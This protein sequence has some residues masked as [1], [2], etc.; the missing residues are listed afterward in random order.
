M[1]RRDEDLDS[2]VE[3]LLQKY[4]KEEAV[5]LRAELVEFLKSRECRAQLE[6]T[7]RK[8][9]ETVI[10]EALSDP[11]FQAQVRD[12]VIASLKPE[13]AKAVQAALK[14]VT[15]TI[16]PETQAQ[17]RRD[18]EEMVRHAQ[19]SAQRDA[20]A[21]THRR[22]G[23]GMATNDK[24]MLGALVVILIVLGVGAYFFWGRGP[25]VES[26]DVVDL[27][28]AET[29]SLPAETTT[30]APPSVPLLFDRYRT[31]LTQA[32][33]P[34]LPAPSPA[35]LTCV[36]NA[37]RQQSGRTPLDVAALRASLNS[38]AATK[39]RPAAP[40]RIIAGVQAQLTEEARGGS[41]RALSPVTIDGRHGNETSAAL[42]TYVGCT[43]PVGVPRTLQTLGDYAAVG[44]YFIDKR[45][46]DAG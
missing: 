14:D 3:G 20:L 27:P 41:C 36:D 40:S 19:A 26:P 5:V 37:I 2:A 22:L 45:M 11:K 15:V 42:T 43:E 28:P 12:T 44:V 13:L 33:S 24:I 23:P 17:M 7:V 10:L 32:G 35:E 30:P 18:A 9:I 25:R 4:E 6:E 8:P 16:P 38:C 39:S 21:S 46:R 31:A 34:D 29:A 1:S